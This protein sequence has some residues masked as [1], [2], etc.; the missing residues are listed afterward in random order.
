MK[1]NPRQLKLS[2]RIAKLRELALSF[3]NEPDA[4]ERG[5][6]VMKSYDETMTE[7]MPI[8][9]A[10]AVAAFLSS[11]TL[12]LDEGDLLCGRLLRKIPAH[13]G[14]HE[15]H[16]W[17][18]AA[19]YPDLGAN[20][21]VLE[22]A[23]VPRDFVSYMRDWVKRHPSVYQK[24]NSLRPAKTRE[25]VEAGIFT[26]SGIDLV[27]RLPRFQLVLDRGIRGL[28]EEA[29]A[30]LKRL[31]ETRAE[32]V[33]KRIFY[34]S[35]IIVYDA[36][37]S[38]AERWAQKLEE[39]A[40][41]ESNNER[42]RELETMAEICRRVPAYPSRNFHEA[43]QAVLFTV[44]I[45]QA[46]TRGSAT[47]LGRFDQYMY[48][49]FRADIESGA[50]TD[51]HALELIECF[52]LKFYRTF[53]FH[54]TT[55]GGVTPDGSDGTN[56]LSYLCLEAVE[57][58][59]VP[60]NITVR[61][62]RNTPREF[63]RKAARV[64]RL[65]LGRPD[66]WNDEVTV[67]ALVSAGIPLVDARDYAPIGCVELTIPGKC[68]S[69][70]MGHSINLAKILEVTLNGGRCALTGKAV[71]LK[72]E[73]DFPTYE[74]LHSAYRRQAAY[75]IR[76]AI[77][78]NVRGYVIQADELP[79]PVLSAFTVGCLESGRDVMN[80]GAIYNPSGVNLFGIAN[81]AD[82]LA[83]IKKFVYDERKISLDEL[84]RALLDDFKGKEPLR[85]MLLT[86]V[87]KFGNDDPYVDEIAAGE[88]D[89]YC[90]EV[91]KYPTPEGGRHH[92]LL[93]GTTSNGIY[94]FGMKTGAT[95]DGRRA[96]A[97]L[98]TS[99]NATHGRELSGVTALLNS[100]SRIDF[101]KAA[102][103]ASFIVDLHPTAVDGEEGLEKLVSLLRTFFDNG[104]MEIG[105]NVVRE[106]ELRE[107]QT[108]PERYG[109]LMVR[110]FG[111]STQFVSLDRDLQEH[112]IEKTK[113][114]G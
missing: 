68:N 79:F 60:R 66:F 30:R 96:R 94:N 47:S 54:L 99:V 11:E 72:N 106:R 44:L 10:K 36:M 87:P 57:R 111:F 8:R 78:D 100:V 84:R 22:D 39:L 69:R 104:G 59:R 40:A 21:H 18:N 107:A 31:D 5:W 52:F 9:R 77:E 63:F 16:R 37:I 6:A 114:I 42:R 110:V 24:L 70:T 65:G 23:P 32:D 61:I 58:L 49:F 50:L 67:G 108:C 3:A 103:G 62:H 64:A 43:L 86:R 80:G 112:I 97:P 56:E 15:G 81:V 88:V 12:T 98:T 33:K 73:T 34:E 28:R 85:Q 14:I 90:R 26:V 45:N 38:Y 76:L 48:R 29:H 101:S 82:S 19:V 4:T 91:A 71:G 27:H 109:H 1:N 7:P 53:D 113:H 51:E 95:A 55:L 41:T 92:P 105:L 35:I 75:F 93:F 13:R 17:V 102:G 74:A 89:F 25:A 46:E 20:P 83:A 2:P